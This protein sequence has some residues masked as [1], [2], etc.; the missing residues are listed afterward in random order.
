MRPQVQLMDT[1]LRDGEQTQRISFP[2]DETV[3]IAK[4]L[5]QSLNVDRISQYHDKYRTIPPLINIHPK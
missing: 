1:T 2:P 4:A 3:S 5:L